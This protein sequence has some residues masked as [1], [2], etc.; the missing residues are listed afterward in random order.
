MDPAS[1]IAAAGMKAN[2][3]SMDV[4]A[5]NMANADTPG[6]KA[7][8]PFYREL[9]QAHGDLAGS[10]VAGLRTDFS[11][12]S[13][14]ITENPLDMAINGQGFFTVRTPAGV[15]YTRNGSFNIGIGGELVTQD[16]YPV[17]DNQGQVI[18][19][20]LNPNQPNQLE[21]SRNGEV[22]IDEQRIA[23]L[24]VVSFADLNQL[25]KLQDQIFTTN[26]LEQPLVNAEVQQGAIE[27]SNASVMDS[28]M[29]M[30]E[31]QRLYEMNSKTIQSVMNSV[32]RQ[33]IQTI[34]GQG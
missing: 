10:T 11:T 9:R 31:M 3:R 1:Y 5:N 14:Q 30:I 28:M 15:G 8:S 29:Q 16:G 12:G 7:D 32:N 21:V 20:V 19:V 22:F 33:A 23:Q 24:N 17:L 13:L 4:I 6:Y 27:K 2:L 34:A 26:Q 18:P 25:E